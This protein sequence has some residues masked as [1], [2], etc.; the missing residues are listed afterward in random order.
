MVEEKKEYLRNEFFNFAKAND[1]LI[2]IESKNS[3]YDDLAYEINDFFGFSE[4]KGLSKK[5]IQGKTIKKFL[6]GKTKNPYGRT[7]NVL[8]AFIEKDKYVSWDGSDD[9]PWREYK[10][11]ARL[12]KKD[13]KDELTKR[14]D[15]IPDPNK[16]LE[17]YNH[18]IEKFLDNDI[19]YLNG[20]PTLY[21]LHE[22]NENDRLSRRLLHMDEGKKY[23]KD[24]GQPEPFPFPSW[25]SEYKDL[26]LEKL[27]VWK[28]NVR[29][30]GTVIFMKDYDPAWDEA[31]GSRKFYLQTRPGKY[32]EKMAI[33]DLMIEKPELKRK[34]IERIIRLG[35]REYFKEPFP[36]SVII[37][38]LI[39]NE[40]KNEFFMTQRS[41]NVD[42]AKHKLCTA[43]YE[44]AK[45]GDKDLFTLAERGLREEFGLEPDE[46]DKIEFCSMNIVLPRLTTVIKGVTKLKGVSK[47]DFRRNLRRSRDGIKEF[48]R[49]RDWLPFTP[50][51][52]YDF[53]QNEDDNNILTDTAKKLCEY[54][55]RN[56]AD[57]IIGST[58]NGWFIQ[59]KYT[60]AQSYR[61][62]RFLKCK[63]DTV[64]V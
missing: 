32:S 37:S 23:M 51:V 22:W 56:G 15:P 50:E 25:A 49:A 12:S 44:T 4:D 42:V 21:T 34:T 10:Q 14:A 39:L 38:I 55:M 43:M 17:I 18:E 36:S 58:Y 20:N 45:F 60:L 63:G 1:Y 35:G 53:I 61:M 19:F 54:S 57:T 27:E 47:N 41:G 48:T 62:M 59:A 7:L 9:V 31:P 33:E 26:Y 64:N 28:K 29:R 8:A 6:S 2:D 3:V 13:G 5:P 46:Y 11:K 30:D 24:D 40:E 52:I 16:D